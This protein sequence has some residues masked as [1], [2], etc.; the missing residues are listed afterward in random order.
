M[1]TLA[2]LTVAYSVDNR[3]SRTRCFEKKTYREHDY[4]LAGLGVYCLWF[5]PGESH[6][7][8]VDQQSQLTSCSVEN[9]LPFCNH[10]TT[11]FAPLL[12]DMMG[13]AVQSIRLWQ[14]SPGLVMEHGEDIGHGAVQPVDGTRDFGRIPGSFAVAG[15]LNHRRMELETSV[16]RGGRV[17]PG[18]S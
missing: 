5:R 18:V 15:P 2:M 1:S 12:F 11:L 13:P 10:A 6:G 4:K 8:S 3:L 7:R 16:R 17:G 14:L 9:M